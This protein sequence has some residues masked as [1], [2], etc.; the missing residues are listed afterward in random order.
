MISA[1]NPSVR[2]MQPL[3]GPASAERARRLKQQFQSVRPR[4]C[5]MSGLGRRLVVAYW[6]GC[7]AVIGVGLDRLYPDVRPRLMEAPLVSNAVATLYPVAQYDRPF[8]NC[9]A[10]HVAGVYDIPQGSPVYTQRQDGDGDGLAC[11]PY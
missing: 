9:A 6:A 2:P 10:A 7:I 5:V 8:P 4:A 11:E 3:E 1:V